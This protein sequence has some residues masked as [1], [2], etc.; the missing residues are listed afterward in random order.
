[1]EEINKKAFVFD[2]TE[3]YWIV[4]E[5]ESQDEALKKFVRLTAKQRAAFLTSREI[6][7]NTGL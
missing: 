3:K 5:G 2:V 6:K 1:M 4:L 7:E